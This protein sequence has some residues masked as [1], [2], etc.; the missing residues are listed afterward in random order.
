[1]PVLFHI[2]LCNALFVGAKSRARTGDP[3]IF[4]CLEGR[5]LNIALCVLDLP[6]HLFRPPCFGASTAYCGL[7]CHFGCQLGCQIRTIADEL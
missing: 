7:G 6:N 4:R 5:P 1:M 3:T 2:G